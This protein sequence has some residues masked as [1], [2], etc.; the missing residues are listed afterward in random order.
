MERVPESWTQPPEPR[1]RHERQASLATLIALLQ[2]SIR[3]IRSNA[4]RLLLPLGLLNDGDDDPAIFGHAS[5]GL[6]FFALGEKHHA[7]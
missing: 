5:I 3:T 2:H 4:E 6:M 1:V 7:V